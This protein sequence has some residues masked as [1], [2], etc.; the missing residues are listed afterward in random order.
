MSS[1]SPATSSWKFLDRVSY[2][3]VVSEISWI[4]VDSEKIMS[5]VPIKKL[6]QLTY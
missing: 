6:S 2:T 5:Q 1:L 4:Y 3:N